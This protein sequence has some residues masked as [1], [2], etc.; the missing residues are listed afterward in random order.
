MV[1]QAIKLAIRIGCVR[2]G[3]L[4]AVVEGSRVTPSGIEQDGA[5]QLVRVPMSEA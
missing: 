3:D 1:F 2:H 4:L 5:L